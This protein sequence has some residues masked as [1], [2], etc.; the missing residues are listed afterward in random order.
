MVDSITSKDKF[1]QIIQKKDGLLCKELDNLFKEI[2][3]IK[4]IDTCIRINLRFIL[5][6]R[7]HLPPGVLL[8]FWG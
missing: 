1:D 4:L 3:I 2:E 8:L 7:H 6:A 5:P